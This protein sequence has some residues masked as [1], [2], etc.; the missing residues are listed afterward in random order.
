MHI[1]K[2]GTTASPHIRLT[3]SGDSREGSIYN[4][5]GGSLIFENHGTD[6]VEDAAIRLIDSQN[7]TI[8]TA[9]VERFRIASDGQFTMGSG[10][11]FG[12]EAYT[13]VSLAN[14][15]WTTAFS[16]GASEDGWWVVYV[17]MEDASADETRGLFYAWSTKSGNSR[18]D[19]NELNSRTNRQ[20]SGNNFQIKHTEG[21]T[22]VIQYSAYQLHKY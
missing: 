16:V 21:S 3:E 13:S 8:R 9:N 14:D 4:D 11:Q 15:T 7:V 1:E 20:W 6:N 5:G 2:T 10:M 12:Q 17:T 18:S 22:R 19:H